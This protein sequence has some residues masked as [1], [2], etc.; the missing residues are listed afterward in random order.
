MHSEKSA[1]SLSWESVAIPTKGSLVIVSGQEFRSDP[2]ISSV[3][4]SIMITSSNSSVKRSR[5]P[6]QFLGVLLHTMAM[7][8]LSC[9]RTELFSLL[10]VPSLAPHP[11]QS[12][13]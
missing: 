8:G 1:I 12:N 13:G 5:M 3:T 4:L 7:F 10:V 2:C 6:S 11:V 9:V